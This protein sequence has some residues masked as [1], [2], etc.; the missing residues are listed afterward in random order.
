MLGA[1][2]TV[3]CLV[4]T[5]R[6]VGFETDS[7]AYYGAASNFAHGRGVSTPFAFL[8]AYPLPEAVQRAHAVPLIDFP[9]L[10]PAVLG[11]LSAVG[12][13]LATAARVLGALLLGVNVV[14]VGLLFLETTR[15]RARPLG[16][17]VAAAMVVGPTSPTYASAGRV[18]WLT[19]HGTVLSE[20]LFV[21][22]ALA[23]LLLAARALRTDSTRVLLAAAACGGLSLLV[24]NVGVAVVA[25]LLLTVLI[26]GDPPRLRRA[27]GVL[28]IGLAPAVAWGLWLRVVDHAR[29]GR[30]FDPHAV[31]GTAGDLLGVFERWVVPAGWPDA[32]RH[33]GVGLLVAVVATLAVAQGRSRRLRTTPQLLLGAYTVVF[34]LVVVATRRFFDVNAVDERILSPVQPAV[35]VLVAAWS[36]SG[37]HM[38]VRSRRA[39]TRAMTAVVL[40]LIAV[41]VRPIASFVARGFPEREPGAVASVVAALPGDRVV[42]S[43]N[44]GEIWLRTGRSSVE[45]PHRLNAFTLEPDPAY[46]RDLAALVRLARRRPTVV[47]FAGTLSVGMFPSLR[48]LSAATTVRDVRVLDDGVVARLGRPRAPRA[49]GPTGC[50]R[51]GAAGP[52]P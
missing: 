46:R 31:T 49:T 45:L 13:P 17:V 38:I 42:V 19:V 39:P 32:L 44:P 21:T 41:S 22:F 51:R 24:R 29:S 26:R 28:A 12:V 40:L 15:N 7:A 20:P 35:F 52:C 2:A 8:S 43:D 14:L 25:A 6:G 16:L 47:V 23:G 10:Y 36:W 27:A 3:A 34:V 11:G 37:L 50:R 30:R 18:N 48:D 33:A 5:R 9:P 1:A 4:A